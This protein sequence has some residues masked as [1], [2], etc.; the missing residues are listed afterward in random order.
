MNNSIILND[1]FWIWNWICFSVLWLTTLIELY[2]VVSGNHFTFNLCRQLKQKASLRSSAAV[3]N[4]LVHDSCVILVCKIDLFS[5]RRNCAYTCI[6]IYACNVIIFILIFI[7]FFLSCHSY[8]QTLIICH[9]CVFCS[10]LFPLLSFISF[11]LVIP[12]RK[13]KQFFVSF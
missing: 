8:L 7:F 13:K 11:Y 9:C 3:D 12:K 6:C 1:I 4:C 10:K 5:Q 2:T